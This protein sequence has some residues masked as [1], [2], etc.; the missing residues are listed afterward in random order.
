MSDDTTPKMTRQEFDAGLNED[1][2][3]GLLA[4]R[5]RYAALINLAEKFGRPDIAAILTEVRAAIAAG[6]KL[7]AGLSVPTTNKESN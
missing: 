3:N 2:V 4:D 1:T 5:V 7:A 6:V